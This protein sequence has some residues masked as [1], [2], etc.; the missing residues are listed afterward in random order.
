MKRQETVNLQQ[1]IW[2]DRQ[3]LADAGLAEPL[4]ITVTPGEI[5]IRP[6]PAAP[7][8]TQANGDPLLDMAGMLSGSP[9]AADEIECELYPDEAAKP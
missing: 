9:L 7:V 1:G 4:E 5:R 2:I 6:A 8:P 3:R